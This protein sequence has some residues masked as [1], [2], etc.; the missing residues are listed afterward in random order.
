MNVK[1]NRFGH[2]DAMRGIAALC[3][4]VQHFAHPIA[5][6]MA[7]GSDLRMLLSA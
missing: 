1:T 3:V 5:K 6:G 4:C 7:E 2:I